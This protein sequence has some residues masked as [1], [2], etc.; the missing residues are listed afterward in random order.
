[1]AL[2]PGALHELDRYGITASVPE[3]HYSDAELKDLCADLHER[4]RRLHEELDRR[5]LS[6]EPSSSALRPFEF[7]AFLLMIL[8]DSLGSRAFALRRMLDAH[9]G[10]EV[11]I[12]SRRPM[13][14]DEFGLLFAP[15]ELLWARVL[16]QME[17]LQRTVLLPDEDLPPAVRRA[18]HI[19]R[20]AQR[21]PLL[22]SLWVHAANRDTRAIVDLLRPWRDSVVLVNRRSDWLALLPAL[23]RSGLRTLFLSEDQFA[24]AS[25]PWREDAQ[26]PL[27]SGL[28]E[29]FLVAGADLRPLLAPRLSWIAG[30]WSDRA[31]EVTRRVARMT[32]RH[33]VRAVLR[34]SVSSGMGHVANQAA[35]EAGAKV[36]VWQHGMLAGSEG[37]GGITQFRDY[38]DM[39]S[40][41][42]VLAYGEGAAEAY[43]SSNRKLFG[44]RIATTG[45]ASLHALALRSP[46]KPSAPPRVLYATTNY[47]ANDW[48][49]GFTPGLSDR[50][51]LRDQVTI[52][53][54]LA[55]Y[56]SVGLCAAMIKLHPASEPPWAAELGRRP[57]VTVHRRETSFTALLADCDVVLLDIPSTTLLQALAA[58]KPTFVLLRH[59]RF[60]TSERAILERSAAVAGE[61]SELC[62][63]LEAHL[64][65]RAFPADPRE[66]T[67]LRRYGTDPARPS[68]DLALRELERELSHH[69]AGTA[70]PGAGGLLKLG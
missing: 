45:S 13:P 56:A 18:H 64:S 49:L 24:P 21:S 52:A 69:R 63:A 16:R 27:L 30:P 50:R 29:V 10:H 4:V 62:R 58:A 32:A 39:L 59:W 42:L 47:Y 57:G 26:L 34:L 5:L 53:D 54:A 46:T 51:L 66:G 14:P 61:A 48:Y 23:H 11:V 36:C 67:F 31:L 68:H 20:L 35:R 8:F 19:R 37:T 55:G 25:L 1:M 38:A 44:A 28:E 65:G 9:P 43:R 70:K 60:A 2:G 17:G 15:G 41:D 12:H 6:G 22:T 33:R 7:H 40:A 3:D